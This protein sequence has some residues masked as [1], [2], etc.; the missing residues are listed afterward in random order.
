[1][2]RII[3]NIHEI[4]VNTAGISEEFKKSFDEADSAIRTISHETTDTVLT[5]TETAESLAKYALMIGELI[6][7]M[8]N[9]FSSKDS[10]R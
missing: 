7:M 10:D 8:V 5:I 4:S 2:N 1:M 9:M 3:L 6:K